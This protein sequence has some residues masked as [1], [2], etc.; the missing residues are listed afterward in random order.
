MASVTVKVDIDANAP[1]R[2]KRMA[3]VKDALT[4]QAGVI[5]NKANGM[6]AG[7]R[8]GY[9]HKNHQSPGIGGTSPVYGYE[10]AKNASRYGS[11]ATVHPKNYAAMK[12][13]YQNNTL[14]KAG[15]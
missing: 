14:L 12:D 11:V 6:S 8:T 4:K 5:C 10:K 2:I 1:E 3:E 15:G 13:N 9:Y 7:F